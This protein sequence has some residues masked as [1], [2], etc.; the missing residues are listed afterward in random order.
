MKYIKITLRFVKI[1]ILFR[2]KGMSRVI[3]SNKNYHVTCNI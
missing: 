3:N 1:S 2:V